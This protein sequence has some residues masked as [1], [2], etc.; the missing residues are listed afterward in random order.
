MG[1]RLR[2]TIDNFMADF[3]AFVTLTYPA[4]APKS[5]LVVK[6]HFRALVERGRRAGLMK[7]QSW[8]WWLEFQ[9]RGAP[10]IHFLSTGWIGKQWI[11]QSWADVT[12]GDARVATRIEGLRTPAAAGAYAAK[13]ASKQVQK[14]VPEEFI[15][16]GRFWGVV[17]EA[18]KIAFSG[19]QATPF[20]SAVKC[21]QRPGVSFRAISEN[22][23]V[24]MYEHPRGYTAYAAE[25]TIKEIW[26]WLKEKNLR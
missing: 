20:L 11:A 9:E 3:V 13:Y 22:F 16:V 7:N 12:G 1:R 18:R 23:T 26:T 10:H 17:G 8:V 24:R 2:F 4:C 25:S 15:D 19:G 6:A 14:V 21:G 5:G